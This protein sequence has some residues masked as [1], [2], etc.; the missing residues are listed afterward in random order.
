MRI[1]TKDIEKE[2]SLCMKFSP[3]AQGRKH[4]AKYV[5]QIY[6]LVFGLN[7]SNNISAPQV[8]VSIY[9]SFHNFIEWSRL[10]LQVK[11]YI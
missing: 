1:T 8:R 9:K 10:N 2:D 11:I 3:K 7:I 6:P 5:L 4:S